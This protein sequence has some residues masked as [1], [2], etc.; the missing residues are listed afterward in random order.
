M[1]SPEY[2]NIRRLREIY[3]NRLENK[4]SFK[5]F[6]EFFNWFDSTVGDIFSD[7]IPKNSKFIGSNVVIESHMLERP[8]FVYSNFNTYL[9]ENLRITDGAE[10]IYIGK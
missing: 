4:I 2:S 8:K 6:F 7:L 5:K 1:Y 3:F 10:E 9:D